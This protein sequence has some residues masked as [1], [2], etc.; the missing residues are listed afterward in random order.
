MGRPFWVRLHRW[1]GLAMTISLVVVGLTGAMLAFLSELNH[2]VTPRLFPPPRDCVALDPASLI[3]RTPVGSGARILGV[4]L[5]EPGV[6]IVIGE[7]A[8]AAS[9]EGSGQYGIFLDPCTGEKLGERRD[10]AF[11]DGWDTLLPFI[12]KLH[13]ALALGSVGVWVQGI[14]ALIWT[15]DCF[16]A[17]YLTF[18]LPRQ[19]SE[20]G[21]RRS[22]WVRWKPSW[23]IKWSGSPYRVNF[24]LHRAG[25]L[26]F[27]PLFLIFGWSSVMFNLNA[28]VYRPVMGVFFDMAVDAEP[29]PRAAPLDNPKLTWREA[30]ATGGQLFIEQGK[31]HNFAAQKPIY[32]AYSLDTGLYFFGVRTSRDLQTHGART[33]IMFDGDTGELRQVHLPSGQAIGSTISTWLGMLHEGNVSMLG[34][35]Y[36]ILVCVLGFVITT[37]GVTGIVIFLKK[38][39]ARALHSRRVV[40]RRV[41]A[42]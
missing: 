30:L 17:F 38:L 21:P 37:L 8:Q 31:I 18:P 4:S 33:W 23:R 42:E 26:W 35:P 22:W 20:D 32:F 10:V 1:A 39:G 6:A 24:D 13:Y 34:L 19:S 14:A 9:S 25:G 11:V 7:V 16:W 15:L 36:R 12:Y 27:Y 3:E 41:L 2:I 28:Q 29:A 40:A 5:D